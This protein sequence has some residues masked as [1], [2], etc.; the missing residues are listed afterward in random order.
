MSV[1]VFAWESVSVYV[2]TRTGSCVL[3]GCLCVCECVRERECVWVC[4]CVCEREWGCVYVCVRARAVETPTVRR[5]SPEQG[6]WATENKLCL[7]IYKLYWS[8]GTVGAV[9]SDVRGVYL[10]EM[11]NA[12]KIYSA[13]SQD[14][15]KQLCVHRVRLVPYSFALNIRGC[16]F[17]FLRTFCLLWFTERR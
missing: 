12:C 13:K 9:G 14:S 8:F 3:S 5:P 4:M 16:V 7:W 17:F 15:W 10:E 2:C 6:S 1:W 11:R